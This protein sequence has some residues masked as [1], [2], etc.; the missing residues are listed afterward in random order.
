MPDENKTEQT[1]T[2]QDFE[3]WIAGQPEEVKTLYDTH[4]TG[5]KN[6]VKATRQE[7]DDFKT[8][9]QGALKEAEKG[10]Q[11]EKSLQDAMAKL[12]ATDRKASFF[13]TAIKPEIGC[14]NI[15]VAY[16]LATSED[17][18]LKDGSPD[19]AAIK[20]TAPELFGTNTKAG[21]GAGTESTIK[22][23]D[24]NSFIRSKTGR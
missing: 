8:Q 7:R 13:E 5:L 9:L 15:R 18:F 20:Q 2:V 14:R 17:L 3:Q 16:A 21:A 24:M 12:E 23:F 19:W 11:L 1:E 4:V 6:T 22:N 10:S